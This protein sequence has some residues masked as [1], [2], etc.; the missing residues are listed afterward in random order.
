MM[1]CRMTKRTAVLFWKLG[2]FFAFTAMASATLLAEEPPQRPE[3]HKP[4]YRVS[5]GP[6]VASLETKTNAASAGSTDSV[7]AAN[8]YHPL[9]DA[10]VLARKSLEHIE[11]NVHDYTCVLVKRERIGGVVAEHEFM[12]C[13]IRH[14]QVTNSRVKPFSVYLGFHRPEAVKGREVLYVAG[15]NEGSLVVHEGGLKGNFIP[16]MS[17]PTN[18]ML[19]MRNNRY[20]ITEVGIKT[21]T[22]RLIEKGERDRE[23]GPCEV[24]I[25]NNTRVNKTRVCTC[26]EVKHDQNKPGLDFHMARVFMDNELQVPIRYEAY[27]WPKTPGGEPELLEEYTYMN[28]KLNVGLTDEDFS[29]DNKKYNF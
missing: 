21:L 7:A 20:P 22:K 6:E 15:E 17:L 25:L 23:L 12:T 11:K 19:A 29:R 10:L 9:D 16:T 8:D 1:E 4:V 24:R 13:K 2:G 5:K 3:L 27:D 14:R 26:V 28:L 18:G